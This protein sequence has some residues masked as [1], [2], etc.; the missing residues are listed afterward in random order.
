MPVTEQELREHLTAAAR[1]AG[2][3]GFT[4]ETVA[5]RIR[6]RRTV[7]A[8]AACA[9]AAV[10]AALAVVLPAGLTGGSAAAPHAGPGYESAPETVREPRFTATVNARHP[11]WLRNPATG[12]PAA[13]C[14]SSAHPCPGRIP[15]FTVTPGERLT[16]TV[17]VSFPARARI[18]GLWIGFAPAIAPTRTGPIGMSPVL[19][20]TQGVRLRTHTYRFSWTVPAKLPP[21]TRQQLV[22]TW[23][24]SL[25]V[26]GPPDIRGQL[27]SDE[28]GTTV[29][30]LAV[31]R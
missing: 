31:A 22:A 7:R 4:V 21:G 27:V 3:P 12:D 15:G 8:T 11:S 16:F 25:P 23:T 10:L 14:G 9:C 18:T 5:A 13:G 24:G 2:P 30:T 29:T 6:R 17:T 28:G 1:Q 26:L 20:H 19:V